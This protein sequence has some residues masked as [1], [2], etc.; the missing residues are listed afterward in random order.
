[1]K[2]GLTILIALT[3]LTGCATSPTNRRQVVLY[4]ES[5]MARQ[6]AQTYEQMRAH[7]LVAE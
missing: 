3:L 6:G 5:D 1:M 2:A 7:R 4:S